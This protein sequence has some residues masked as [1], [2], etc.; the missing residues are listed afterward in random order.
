MG[1]GL[2]TRTASESRGSVSFFGGNVGRHSTIMG[3]MS[4]YN[5]CISSSSSPPSSSSSSVHTYMSARCLVK[6]VGPCVGV[7]GSRAQCEGDWPMC[8]ESFTARKVRSVSPL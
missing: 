5:L 7:D 6:E 8:L 4:F 3:P 1:A 2:K